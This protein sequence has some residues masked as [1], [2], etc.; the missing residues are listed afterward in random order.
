MADE[1]DVR[2]EVLQKTLKEVADEGANGEANDPDPCVICLDSIT[3]PSVAIPCNHSNFDYLC[4]LSWLE[5]QPS[6]PLCKYLP[7]LP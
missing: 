7:G 3:E 1:A 2:H 6:C 5:Q 4:L